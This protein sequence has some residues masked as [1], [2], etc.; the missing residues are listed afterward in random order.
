[1]TQSPRYWA[2]NQVIK[3]ARGADIE[4]KISGVDELSVAH[5]SVL[6]EACNTS[7]QLHLQIA[8]EDFVLVIIGLKRFQDL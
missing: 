2:M 4:L 5:D 7:F 6:F 1:M 3:E 8:P